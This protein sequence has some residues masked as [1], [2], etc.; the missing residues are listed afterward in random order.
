M[1]YLQISIT[2]QNQENPNIVVL[3]GETIFVGYSLTHPTNGTTYRLVLQNGR[4]RIQTTYQQTRPCNYHHLDFREVSRCDQPGTVTIWYALLIHGSIS[5]SE[6]VI[7]CVLEI[8]G[9]PTNLRP[10]GDI[11][12]N[13]IATITVISG[14]GTQEL[15]CISFQRT[16]STL[17]PSI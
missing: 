16:P 8:N 1:A 13:V 2:R 5:V 12:S 11:N 17:D 15:L 3:D 7:N 10:C 9:D 6:E 14:R 4:G